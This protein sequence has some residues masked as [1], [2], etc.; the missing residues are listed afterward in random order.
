MDVYSVQKEKFSTPKQ[1]QNFPKMI[2]IKTFW[3][4]SIPIGVLN[5]I[6]GIQICNLKTYCKTPIII[7]WC[8]K[9]LSHIDG[10][11]HF[12]CFGAESFFF[13]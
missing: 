11:N 9:D 6:P 4:Q 8:K 12:A 3:D 7:Q 2:K 10:E 1:V 13:F 5:I